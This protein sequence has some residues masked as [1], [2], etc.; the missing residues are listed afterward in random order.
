MEELSLLI[1]SQ[2]LEH[3][4]ALDLLILLGLEDV[5]NMLDLVLSF[6]LEVLLSFQV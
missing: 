2:S 3:G 5:K 1:V 6:K 4:E